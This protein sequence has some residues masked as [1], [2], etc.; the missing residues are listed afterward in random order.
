MNVLI[1]DEASFMRMVLRN[2]IEGAGYTVVGEAGS[3]EE[4]LMEYLR[5]RPCVVT[6]DLNMPTKDGIGAIRKI[7]EYDP[8]CKVLVT[9]AMGQSSLIKEALHAG[10]YDFV[11]KPVDQARLLD[12]L[13]EAGNP[14]RF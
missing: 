10:A 11:L 13:R 7:R 14:H 12:V 4:A 5:K 6:I 3:G 2:I 1:V 9:A 8:A